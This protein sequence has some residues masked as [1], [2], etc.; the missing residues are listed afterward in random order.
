MQFKTIKV[1]VPSVFLLASILVGPANI[2]ASEEADFEVIMLGV[3]SPP[4]FMN[5]FG[6]GTLIK[7]GDKYLRIYGHGS[8]H[9][10]DRRLSR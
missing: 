9:P 5:R 6:P 4:P 7:A 1:L 3:G 8:R 10:S 2:H